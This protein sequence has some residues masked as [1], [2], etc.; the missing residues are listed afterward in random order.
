M[1]L[2]SSS[3]SLNT[4]PDKL[5]V[6]QRAYE[7]EKTRRKYIEKMLEDRSRELYASQ[8]KLLVKNKELST[9]NGLLK[10][11]FRVL[12]GLS[13]DFERVKQ[14]LTY[15]SNIQ[16]TF[17][18]IPLDSQFIAA[19]G[20]LQPAQF[21]A[22][23]GLD[24]FHLN[25]NLFAFYLID[26]AGHGTAAAMLSFA[27]Q[28][29][30]N[31][32]LDGLCQKHLEKSGNLAET[33][34]NTLKELNQN[35]FSEHSA[36]R[37]F[38]MIYGLV[39]L[40]TGKVTFGQAGHPPP[41]H[42]QSK[43]GTAITQGSNGTPVAL[44]DEPSFGIYTF[45]MERGDRLVVYSD[46]VTECRNLNDEEFGEENLIALTCKSSLL[47]ISEQTDSITN[48]ISQWNGNDIFEDD[49]SI[50]LLEYR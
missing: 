39:S 46:G 25:D 18:P 28:I 34:D 1:T 2:V 31:P 12:S 36:A 33:V 35:F 49:V 5:A 15:A 16:E 29:Q 23:D 40:D 43:K 8:Q 47:P 48:A 24:Y 45:D 22:G 19:A 26:V 3:E 42:F 44:F 17:L 32:K 37:Y 21:I 11:N 20:K 4:K 50:L 30:L 9:V 7:R 13:S 6:I 38:T 41:V 27:V 10:E 14:D